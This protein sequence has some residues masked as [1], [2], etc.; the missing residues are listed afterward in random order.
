MLGH[1]KLTVLV[2]GGI[3]AAGLTTGARAETNDEMFCRAI[4]I[5]EEMRATCAAD[6]MAATTPE[7][8]D[9]IAAAWVAKSPIAS[10]SPSSLYQPPVDSNAKNGTPGTPYQ[11][12]I[13][14]SNEVA[15]QINRAVK[16]NNDTTTRRAP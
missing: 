2:L 7:A 10:N 1:T 16:I 11:D 8:K 14:V 6:M 15:A 9:Q 12:K 5:A 4:G 13:N 3:M